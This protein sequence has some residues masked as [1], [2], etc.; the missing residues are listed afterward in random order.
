M[1][2]I[3]LFCLCLLILY[4]LLGFMGYLSQYGTMEFVK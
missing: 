2:N 3:I 1:K 4:L